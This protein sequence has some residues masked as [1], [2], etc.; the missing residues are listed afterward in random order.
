LSAARTLPSRLR[1]PVPALLTVAALALALAAL[2]GCGSSSPTGTSASPA[3]VVP[4][5]APLYID[6]VVSPS[7]SLKS[8]ALSAGHALTERADPYA[9]LLKLLQGPTGKAPSAKEVQPWLGENA[10]VFLSSVS[11]TGVQSTVGAVQGL[12]QEALSKAI[13]EGLAGAEAALVGSGGLSS[14]LEQSSV[15]G[16]LVLDTT[17]VSS[18]RAFLEAQA[19]SAGAHSETYRGIVYQVAPDGV[20]EGVVHRFAV[21]G[22]EAGVKSVIETALGG[23]SLAQAAD[24]SKLLSSAEPGRLANA[25]LNVQALAGA[26]KLGGSGGSLLSL[27]SGV[28]GNA[29]QV[30]ASLI[31][32]S[33]SLA[34][35]LDTLPSSAAAGGGGS[36]TTGAQVLRGL[37]SGAWLALGFGDLGKT[38]SG[39]AQALRALTA[40]LSGISLGSFSIGKVF[41]PFSSPAIDVQRDLL[42][43]M[44]ATGIYVG[45]TSILNLQAAVVVD[46]KNPALARA[47]VAKLAAAYQAAGGATSPTSIAGTETAQT[48]RLPGFPLTLTMAYGQGKFILG[49]GAASIKEALHPQ[50]TLAGT[51]VYNTAA[52]ALGQGIEPS[53][54]IEFHTLLGL[55]ESVGLTQAPGFSGIAQALK[56]ISSLAAGGKTLAGGVKRARLTLA[57]TAGG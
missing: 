14:L 33:S 40:V 50:S 42:S 21:I 36:G 5:A 56:P 15:Q 54:A 30:Y 28:L 13:A 57:L 24:Y 49:L 39:G 51:S 26:V 35:D 9:G 6:A 48:I 46:A 10:G 43:W 34:L 31:P 8:D 45:G 12:L 4:A 23:S 27:L 22:S 19:K 16:A 52:N 1:R 2:A 53:A 32:S 18:A 7:G 41:A 3:S 44:G 17:N 20:A 37:P 38:L 11:A 29:G 55:L 25:Y 47:A